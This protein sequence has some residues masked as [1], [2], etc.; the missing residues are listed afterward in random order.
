MIRRY[1]RE[2]KDHEFATEELKVDFPLGDKFLHQCL[3]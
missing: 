3:I 2:M 1:V